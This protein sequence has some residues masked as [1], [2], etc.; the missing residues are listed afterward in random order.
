EAVRAEVAVEERDPC[1]QPPARIHA[2]RQRGRRVI[3]RRHEAFGARDLAR[4]GRTSPVR[5]R[6]AFDGLERTAGPF[7]PRRLSS[8]L[9]GDVDRAAGRVGAMQGGDVAR[10]YLD[11]LDLVER[12]WD[13]A[14]V[15]SRLRVVDPGAVDQDERLPE[16]RTA[17][18]EVRLYARDAA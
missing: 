10:R 5:A 3:T 16:R 6:A 15:V 2:P 4:Q 14:V 11:A 8:A 18:G 17:H 13:V 7:D 1:D 9:R 12:H